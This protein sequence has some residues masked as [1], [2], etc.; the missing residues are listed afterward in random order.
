MTNLRPIEET[1]GFMEKHEELFATPATVDKS[2]ELLGSRQTFQQ[3]SRLRE[4]LNRLG[5]ELN[6]QGGAV[7]EIIHETT[8]LIRRLDILLN[9]R[10]RAKTDTRRLEIRPEE[11]IYTHPF[12]RIRIHGI[13]ATETIYSPAKLT[14]NVGNPKFKDMQA[15]ELEG[16]RDIFHVLT[17]LFSLD[18]LPE[19]F[20]GHLGWLI[21]N[22]TMESLAECMKDSQA[23][24][25]VWDGHEM[26]MDTR[27]GANDPEQ[28]SIT[29]ISN[30]NFRRFFNPDSLKLDLKHRPAESMKFYLSKLGQYIM[31][32][33]EKI[34]RYVQG[35]R[36]D[37]VPLKHLQRFKY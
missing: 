36:K 11:E 30:V 7:T 21:V 32:A 16:P 26:D 20:R 31:A 13:N 25:R 27:N 14:T 3:A 18:E 35:G 34:M 9:G 1:R 10:V 37:T 5:I 6:I 15:E 33:I 17:V 2:A 19:E 28:N 4:G 23:I 29:L 8:T 24:G 12:Q 22:L